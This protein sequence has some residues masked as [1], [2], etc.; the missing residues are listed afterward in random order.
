MTNRPSRSRPFTKLPSSGGGGSTTIGSPLEAL[1]RDEIMRTRW[2]CLIAAAIAFVGGISVPILPGDPTASA[3]LLER[4]HRR[5]RRDRVPLQPHARPGRVPQVEYGPR[6]VRPGRRA[7]R[8]RFRT[9]ACS[10]RSPVVLVLG[11]YFTGLGKSLRL[12]LAVYAMCAG[13]Q[14]ARRDPRDLR[15][16]RHR[17]RAAR[18]LRDSRSDRRPGARPDRPARDAHHRADVTPHRAARGRRARARRPRRCASRGAPAR[19]TRGAR[20]RAAHRPRP[21]HRSDDRRLPARR[22][23]SAAARWARSTRPTTRDGATVAIKLLSQASL[24]QSQPRAAVP[25]RAAHRRERSLAEHR[26][27]ARGR[28]AP[29]AVPRDGAARGQDARRDAARPPRARRRTRSSTSSARSAPASPPRPPRASSIA[30]SSRRTCSSTTASW[31][32]LDFGVARA[33]RSRRHA[34]RGPGRRHAVVHGARAGARRHRRSRAPISTRSP[35]SRIA[36]SPATRRSPPARLPRRSTAS[37]TPA[38]RR[39]SDLA[40][41]PPEVDLGARDRPR[42]GAEP[43]LPLGPRPRLGARRCLRR[44]ATA[45]RVRARQRARARWRVGD[46]PAPIDEP[47]ARAALIRLLF[48]SG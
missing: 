13:M 46:E 37:S 9:S 27:G 42:E 45:A 40:D 33:R 48:W 10:R 41:V 47:H 6:L 26:R 15:R 5:V 31:K 8:R 23:C 25:A 44:L 1:E 34:H 39:P 17:P 32:I 11:I 20:A 3:L 36:R 35:R 29:G 16:A 28:R 7:S 43:A 4:G 18:Q 19:G 21:V 24:S 12:S 30:T 22:P 2:F 14:A 38:P